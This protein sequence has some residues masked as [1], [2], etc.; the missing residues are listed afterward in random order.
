MTDQTARTSL[1]GIRAERYG[2]ATTA[3]HS[4]G[5]TVL[6][7]LVCQNS[8]IV[9]HKYQ[10]PPVGV[11][12]LEAERPVVWGSPLDTPKTEGPGR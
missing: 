9:V 8:S 6:V 1:Q 2:S 10:D 5:W 7:R 11:P 3:R 12:C 4:F